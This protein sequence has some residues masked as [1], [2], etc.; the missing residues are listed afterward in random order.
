[1]KLEMDY[2]GVRAK[3]AELMLKY[4]VV[5]QADLLKWGSKYPDNHLRTAVERCLLQI[6]P[7]LYVLSMEEMALRTQHLDARFTQYVQV[8][9]TLLCKPDGST[10]VIRV[11]SIDCLCGALLR[12]SL[13]TF[14]R[15]NNL[16][17]A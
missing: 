13:C 17:S 8:L 6:K 9:L 16:W 15:N 12:C 5:G 1:M 14:C 2:E 10:P 4:G 3:L 7:K 11:E